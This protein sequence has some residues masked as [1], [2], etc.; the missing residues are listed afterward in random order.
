M[1]ARKTDNLYKAVFFENDRKVNSE[2]HIRLSD[3]EIIKNYR[4]LSL[5][6]DYC[7]YRKMLLDAYKKMLE[8]QEKKL[9]KQKK[10]YDRLLEFVLHSSGLSALQQYTKVLKKQYS[11]QLL[12]K[13][14]DFLKPHGEIYLKT[15]DDDL[16]NASK[17]Y[18]EQCG[19][20]IIK[21]TY[22]LHSENS[23][24]NIITEH[25]EM[26]SKQGIKIKALIAKLK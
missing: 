6:D 20:E 5:S 15:D 25:E 12:E 26:F 3:F 23:L 8:N 16:F 2:R 9:E 13:Y 11:Q 21:I 4:I 18:F 1:Q 10:L 24:E 14:K 19:F 17:G 7:H 22:D